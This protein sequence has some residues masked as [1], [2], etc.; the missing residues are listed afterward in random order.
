MAEK[1]DKLEELGVEV[2][3]GELTSPGFDPTMGIDPAMGIPSSPF[4]ISQAVSEADYGVDLLSPVNLEKRL[5]KLPLNL[6][7]YIPLGPVPNKSLARL[8]DTLDQIFMNDD[9][10]SAREY[11][12]FSISQGDTDKL[13]FIGRTYNS[14]EIM[15]YTLNIIYQ[16][17]IQVLGFVGNIE[18]KIVQEETLKA[19]TRIAQNRG[20]IADY[21]KKYTEDE[22]NEFRIR[23]WNAAKTVFENLPDQT[24]KFSR[25]C[26]SR[27]GELLNIP[28]KWYHEYREIKCSD[29]DMEDYRQLLIKP[30]L[31]DYR[32]ESGEWIDLMKGADKLGISTEQI[33]EEITKTEYH[34]LRE[35]GIQLLSSKVEGINPRS[36]KDRGKLI[37][38]FTDDV[39]NYVGVVYS[40]EHFNQFTRISDPKMHLGYVERTVPSA[41]KAAEQFNILYEALKEKIGIKKNTVIKLSIDNKTERVD[42]EYLLQKGYEKYKQVIDS[43]DENA[44]RQ[45]ELIML[46]TTMSVDEAKKHADGMGLQIINELRGEDLVAKYHL[47]KEKFP[48]VVFLPVAKNGKL[49]YHIFHDNTSTISFDGRE[50]Y[51]VLDNYAQYVIEDGRLKK[52]ADDPGV[53]E[54][55]IDIGDLEA[56]IFTTKKHIKEKEQKIAQGQI[57][58]AVTLE[59]IRLA[60]NTHLLNYL[61]RWGFTNVIEDERRLMYPQELY[62]MGID[63]VDIVFDANAI[64]KASYLALPVLT[65]KAGIELG[66]ADHYTE[67]LVVQVGDKNRLRIGRNYDITIPVRVAAVIEEKDITN[68]SAVNQDRTRHHLPIIGEFPTRLYRANGKEGLLRI[69]RDLYNVPSRA[70]SW[71]LLPER[72]KP[73]LANLL[74]A[75]GMF[76]TQG[77]MYR[78]LQYKLNDPF[79]NP[80]GFVT[81]DIDV[82]AKGSAVERVIEFGK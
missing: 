14:Y 72:E 58:E 11:W 5:E 44:R 9:L 53:R 60:L 4:A 61:K 48:L 10:D 54:F 23:A 71:L 40:A 82:L 57:Q 17:A 29:C 69:G 16:K 59:P 42:F 13:R 3:G 45:H 47:G 28:E 51:V 56:M 55:V 77:D 1:K 19:I 70:S 37:R 22:K 52:I 12:D 50:Y 66:E 20:V 43:E 8:A 64:M 32:I 30:T 36:E 75:G 21:E 49:R 7:P 78:F 46:S 62:N 65:T 81:G 33:I 76:A 73:L 79:L 68:A 2:D 15:I 24:D 25:T 35:F 18:D 63:G 26:L 31:A 6:I 80:K 34:L 39:I 41:V 38:K 67:L 74:A 27:I